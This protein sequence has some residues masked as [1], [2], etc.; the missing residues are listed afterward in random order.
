MNW[1]GYALLDKDNNLQARARWALASVLHE[2]ATRRCGR[3]SQAPLHPEWAGRSAGVRP[4]ST[5]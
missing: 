2:D 1:S 5:A 4:D 3:S